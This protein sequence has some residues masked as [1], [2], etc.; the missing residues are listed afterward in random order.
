MHPSKA[1]PTTAKPDV[2]L[3][4]GFSD[5]EASKQ[6]GLLATPSKLNGIPS[7]S[8]TF[9]ASVDTGLSSAAQRMMEDVRNQAAKFKAEL[10]AQ[11][12]QGEEE[13]DAAPEAISGRV[14]A[15]PRGKSGRFSAAH[16]AEFKKM[17]SI[18]GHASAWRAQNGRF[19]P[20]KSGLK[21]S[22][23]KAEL[24]GATAAQGSA[25]K[26]PV[27]S[28]RLD[29]GLTRPPRRNLK[30]TST[31]ANLDNDTPRRP[32]GNTLAAAPV[33]AARE[34][35]RSSSKRLK[36]REEDDASSARP[37]SRDNGGGDD[38]SAKP[39]PG[40]ARP[41]GPGK[42][43]PAFA[44]LSS[45][46]PTP[47]PKATGLLAKSVSTSSIGSASATADAKRRMLSPGRFHKVKS[48]LRGHRPDA[49][50]VRSAIPQ[51]ALRGSQTPAPP[52][53][54]KELLQA[55]QT[56]PRRKL[57]KR[58]AF[59]PETAHAAAVGEEESPSP[60]KKVAFSVSP[61]G[62]PTET[63]KAPRGAADEAAAEP[64]KSGGG[65]YPDLSPLRRLLASGSA[66]GGKARAAA[67]PGTFT[68]RSD[69]TIKFRG[70]VDATGFGS[71]PG[72]ASI[73]HVQGPPDALAASLP[74]SFPEPPSP[75]SHPDKENAAPRMLPG[76]AHGIA[77]KKRHRPS[78][79]EE[80]AENEAAQRAAKKLKNESVPE[81]QALLAPRLAGATAASSAK[82]RLLGRTPL[83]ST[84]GRTPAPGPSATLAPGP[85]A[86]PSRKGAVMSMSR[87]NMLARP[88]NRG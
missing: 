22:P 18:E 54:T 80:D 30:R 17:D 63:L 40:P 49:D 53:L 72:Q 29:D 78:S 81:G 5:V 56:T 38:A 79:D 34:S 9:Q 42:A 82:K 70:G 31:A 39:H 66:A 43:S 27:P 16:V 50:G 62:A 65:L 48:I 61:G 32:V 14:I 59:T 74:G 86:T 19:T 77:N 67:V 3:H 33:A 26:P 41:T 51:P 37:A 36:K 57:T 28:A 13:A 58:V 85:S 47:R 15:K 25:A 10:V 55:P 64:H 52:R 88:K 45:A 68:F 83:K 4:L 23:S 20:V 21:R 2:A 84:P 73:R 60:K 7:T 35:Y 1:R 12:A 8:F 11:R 75:S 24:D 87:L 44:S 46:L 76:R 71:C 69:H 6:R